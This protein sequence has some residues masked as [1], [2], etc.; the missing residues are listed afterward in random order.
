MYYQLKNSILVVE[1][2]IYV[3]QFFFF[4]TRICDCVNCVLKK[5]ALLTLV[6]TDDLMAKYFFH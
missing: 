6:T 5:L 2:L 1:Q 3:L 4:F